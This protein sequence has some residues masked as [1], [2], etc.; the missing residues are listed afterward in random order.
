MTPDLDLVPTRRLG[1]PPARVWRAWTDP[2]Q[3][4]QWFVPAPWRL[5]E[6][7]MD[8]R[9]GGRFDTVMAGPGGERHE[10]IDIHQGWGTALNQLSALLERETE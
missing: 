4:K 1:A 10:A 5:A 9:P 7:S 2:G 3:L 6:V 8:V